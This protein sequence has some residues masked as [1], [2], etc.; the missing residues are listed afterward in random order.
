[1]FLAVL[2]TPPNQSKVLLSV[3]AAEFANEAADDAAELARDDADDAREEGHRQALLQQ[4]ALQVEQYWEE[5]QVPAR[6]VKEDETL[7]DNEL[8]LELKSS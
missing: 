4:E 7:L 5:E 6:D 1:M 3:D 2:I 8:K